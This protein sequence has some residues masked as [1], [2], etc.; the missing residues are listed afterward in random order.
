MEYD[1]RQALQTGTVLKILE[2]SSGNRWTAVVGPEIGRGGSCLVYSGVQQGAVGAEAVSRPVIIKEFFPKALDGVLCRNADGSLSCPEEHRQAF[3]K[4]LA[5]F[6]AGQANH[7]LFAAEH[8]SRS[9]PPLFASGR[10]NG[11]FYALSSPGQGVSMDRLCRGDMTLQDALDLI[12]S[13]SDAVHAVHRNGLRLYLDLKP[14]NIYVEDGRALLFDF[15]T[16][17]PKERLRYCSCSPGWSAPEQELAD[18]ETGYADTKKIGFHTDIYAIAAV[19]FYLLTG[20]K[21]SPAD[22]DAVRK[23][24]D[25]KALVTLRDPSGALDSEAFAAELDRVM[26]SALQTDPDLRALDWGSAGAALKIRNDW[27]A[28]RAI[29]TGVPDQRH[30]EKTQAAIEKTGEAVEAARASVEKTVRRY[31][32]KEFLFGTKKRALLTAAALLLMAAVVGAAAGLIGRITQ[33][34]PPAAV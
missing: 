32:L 5:A 4:R 23:G 25:W 15:D 13:V 7:I 26:R 18:G 16:V 21:P 8:A 24:A 17:Q 33:S 1:R 20:R 27:A 2:E 28:L 14:A 6:C 3:E 29:A 10:A 19:F 12:I 34:A 11:T 31:S 22:L 9:L 30:F